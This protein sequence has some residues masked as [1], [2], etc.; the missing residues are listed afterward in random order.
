MSQNLNLVASRLDERLARDEISFRR[1][2]HYPTL[3]LV[4]NTGETDNDTT[5]TAAGVAGSTS[6]F[7]QTNESI[8]IQF[9]CRCLRAAAHHRAC[10]R[11]STCTARLASSCSE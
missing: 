11:P 7:V 1:N 9:T 4:A 8:G 5:Y 10:A 2:G 6:T 3:E